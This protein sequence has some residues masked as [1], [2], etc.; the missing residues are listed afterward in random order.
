[1]AK[2]ARLE[3]GGNIGPRTG[4]EVV[5][6]F[7]EERIERIQPIRSRVG[8]NIGL[9]PNDI[10]FDE[11]HMGPVRVPQELLDTIRNNSLTEWGWLGN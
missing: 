6:G 11:I 7:D 8:E 4:N 10:A 1:M 5:V 3:T 9:R 2:Q